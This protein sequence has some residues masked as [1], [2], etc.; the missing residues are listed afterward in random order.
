MPASASPARSQNIRTLQG[1]HDRVLTLALIG[2]GRAGRSLAAA[3]VRAGHRV[4][5]EDV[6][7]SR[8]REALEVIPL[9]G[10]PGTLVTVSTVED[11]V[12]EADLVIDFVPDEL[13]SKLEI[14]CMADRMAP[15]KT[16]LC[17]QTSALSVTDLASCTYRAERCIGVVLGPTVQI[18]RGAHTSSDTV[19]LIQRFFAS[20]GMDLG[21]VVSS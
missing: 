7:P 9:D 15:P 14:V 19:A 10:M 20:C 1:S 6:L 16:V 5:L 17:I 18:L 8:L 21:E 3:A 2:A 4:M 13:E 11:A 12:R